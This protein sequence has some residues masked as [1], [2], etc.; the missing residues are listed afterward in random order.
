M[1][2]GFNIREAPCRRQGTPQN[3]GRFG[4]KRN[5]MMIVTAGNAHEYVDLGLR[6]T[7]TCT[8]FSGAGYRDF[9]CRIGA[10]RS[11]D[12]RNCESRWPQ[13]HRDWTFAPGR[14]Y[15]SDVL[16]ARA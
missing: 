3:E 7:L 4:G 14:E 15:L 2:Q 12:D 5:E 16:P 8:Q 9:G 13:A 11:H 10:G 1:P 6:R